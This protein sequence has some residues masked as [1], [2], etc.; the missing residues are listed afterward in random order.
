MFKLVWISEYIE[1]SVIDDR[2]G[3]VFLYFAFARATVGFQVFGYL[4]TDSIKIAY[5]ANYIITY[6]R[7]VLV[8]QLL[9]C[10][11]S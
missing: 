2:I 7:F 1:I 4:T 10:F 6:N 8:D 5:I 11:L 3:G 9:H